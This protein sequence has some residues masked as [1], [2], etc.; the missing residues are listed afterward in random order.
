MN[1][2][3]Q[4]G[5]VRSALWAAYGDILGFPT[6]LVDEDGLKRRIGTSKISQATGWKRLIGGHFGV[7]AMLNAG[8]YSD[9]T[10]LRLATSRSIRG[11]GHFDVETFA[12]IELPVWLSYCLGAGRGSKLGATML[13]QRG[14]NW[15]SNFF[16]QRAVRYVDGGGNGAAMRIQPHVWASTDLGIAETYIPDVIRNSLCTHG[17]PRGISG[18]VI[19][20]ACLAAVLHESKIPVPT[21]WVDLVL[22]IEL[23]QKFIFEDPELSTFWLPT[24]E[25]KAGRSFSEEMEKVKLEWIQ[26]V[27]KCLPLLN[28][29]PKIAYASVVQ[30]LGGF[31]DNSRGS[32]IKCALFALV[33]AWCFR[34]MPT[35]NGLVIVANLLSSDTDTIGTMAGALLGAIAS[36]EPL[37]IVQDKKYITIEA[38]RLHAISRGEIVESFQYPDLMTWQA[39]R[40]QLDTVGSIGAQLAFAGLGLIERC[41]EEFVSS[42]ADYSYQWFKLEFGQTI[43]CKRRIKI[44]EMD[45]KAL[46]A[47]ISPLK[48]YNPPTDLEKVRARVPLHTR[49]MFDATNTPVNDDLTSNLKIAAS[50]KKSAVSDLEIAKTK[51]VDEP[52]NNNIN[53]DVPL[54]LNKYEYSIDELTDIAIKSGFDVSIIGNDLLEL[55]E[56][57]NGIE[58]AISYAAIVVKARR[59]RLQRGKV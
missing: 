17:H 24:W 49:D 58:L 45:A 4:Q 43:L 34:E 47:I 31:D 52:Q 5:I 40:T 39:P 6:E 20:A 32:G 27:E 35:E 36:S 28:Q 16:D 18:A 48:T 42:K 30:M 14:V 56:R 54:H 59:A 15:F 22:Y 41:S 3:L 29:D 53:G 12:K 9:D 23:A 21:D 44:D 46:P 37:D 38:K 26:D 55:A 10:Q 33:A 1:R 19:H 50:I 13:G 57:Q 2:T 25:Q 7:W 51:H 8:T 11:D